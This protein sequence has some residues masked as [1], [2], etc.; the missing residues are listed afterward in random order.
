MH[1]LALS[2]PDWPN[3]AGGNGDWAVDR[4]RKL[5]SA[6]A[7][8]PR[9]IDTAC[10]LDSRGALFECRPEVLE[11]LPWA[12]QI[13]V[14][15]LAL[16]KKML[17]AMHAE[18]K[19]HGC[20]VA[21]NTLVKNLRNGKPKVNLANRI[22]LANFINTQIATNLPVETRSFELAL[23]T[24]LCT[25]GAS[26]QGAATARAGADGVRL[27]K[28]HLVTAFEARGFAVEVGPAEVGPWSPLGEVEYGL[29]RPFLRV[30]ERLVIDLTTKG[31]HPDVVATLDGT[32]LAVGEV[33]AR[34]DLSNT[35]ESWVPSIVDHLRTWQSQSPHAARL[36]FGTVVTTVMIEG[37]TVRGTAHLGLRE[38]REC[39]LLHA[40]YNLTLLAA[41]NAAAQTS[42]NQLVDSLVDPL[43]TGRGAG[44]GKA[45]AL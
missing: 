34:K 14:D 36:F 13:Y 38:L 12:A 26:H 28:T 45:A 33:K 23:A 27:L 39:G 40:V 15:M 22:G 19:S 5:A 24:A 9:I 1:T 25:R 29:D 21:A 31:D 16:S 18:V 3:L 17:K 4:S 44:V 2:E 43:R 37:K 30:G 35:W 20:C 41:G 11:E 8:T 32:I 6:A 7:E 42:F 10:A